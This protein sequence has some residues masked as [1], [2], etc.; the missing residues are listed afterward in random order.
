MIP[1]L[2]RGEKFFFT[3]HPKDNV[4]AAFPL[5]FAAGDP[6]FPYSQLRLTNVLS[7]SQVL[8]EMQRFFHMFSLVESANQAGTTADVLAVGNLFVN[9]AAVGCDANGV[10][11]L[12]FSAHFLSNFY[13]SVSDDI[14]GLLGLRSGYW[15]S[16]ANDGS[17]VSAETPGANLVALVQNALTFNQN[18]VCNQCDPTTLEG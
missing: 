12:Q 7:V 18:R 17:L 3:I 14:S 13:V 4:G 11:N 8:D 16:T 9:H 1:P 10:I 2:W 5:A 15:A 6:L